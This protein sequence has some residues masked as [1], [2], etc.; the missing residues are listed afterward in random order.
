MSDAPAH[1][2]DPHLPI[3]RLAKLCKMSVPTV[4]ATLPMKIPLADLKTYDDAE[5]ARHFGCI[6]EPEWREFCYHF[7]DK[8]F[9]FTDLGKA[10]AARHAE[11]NGLPLPH[12][13]R[14]PE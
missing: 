9:K 2:L 14:G 12:S 11:E 3:C 1:W 13:D 7:R 6:T 5:I 8:T 10:D 4:K